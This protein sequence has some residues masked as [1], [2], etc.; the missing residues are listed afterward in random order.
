MIS[1]LRIINKA[2]GMTNY[3]IRK[4]RL[5]RLPCEVCS[6]QKT[7]AHHDDYNKPLEVR[8]LCRKHHREFHTIKRR[9]Q[10]DKTS[11]RN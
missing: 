2:R 7:E 9:K 4:E 8:W 1:K 5:K 11:N 6:E 10:N 3:A